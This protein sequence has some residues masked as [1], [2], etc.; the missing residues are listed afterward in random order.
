MADTATL[1]PE[2]RITIPE[3]VRVARGWEA[4][5]TLAFVPKG[6]SVL[7]VPAPAR[8]TLAGIARGTTAG[9]ERDRADRV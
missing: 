1:C 2:F 7:L 3:S 4:G 9:D 8:E 5:L 6:A